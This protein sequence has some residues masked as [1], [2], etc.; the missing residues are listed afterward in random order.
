[1]PPPTLALLR[2]K[3]NPKGLTPLELG[4]TTGLKVETQAITA[5]GYPFGDRLAVQDG[6]YPSVSVNVGRITALRK[7]KMELEAIQVDAQV[8]P[9]NSGGPVTDSKGRVIG[10]IT[11]GVRGAG[12]NFAVPVSKVN[13][14]LRKPEV[15]FAPSPIPVAKQHEATRFTVRLVSFVNPAPKVAVEL[16][17]T[18]GGAERKFTATQGTNG[19][20]TV[21]AVPVPAAAGPRRVP[22]TLIFPSGRVQGSVE[23][24]SFKVGT[25]SLRLS[26]VREVNPGDRGTA[27]T[28]AG[29]T[30]SGATSGLGAVPVEFGGYALSVDL[31]KTTRI[32][33]EYVEVVP[34]QIE[35]VLTVTEGGKALNQLKGAIRIDG[36]P[37]RQPTTGPVRIDAPNLT[38][39]KTVVTLP[40]TFED[41]WVGGNGRYLIF[42]LRRLNKLAVFDVSAAKVIQYLPAPVDT[43]L[44]AAGADKLVLIAREKKTIERWTLVTFEKEVTA[45]LPVDFPVDRVASGAGRSGRYWCG[46][47]SATPPS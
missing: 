39:E 42:H 12:V 1:M 43:V 38:T 27:V 24:R 34:D 10:V 3:L 6:K 11:A 13:E 20:F 18:V 2:V 44:G 31:A 32:V 19:E 8:N 15:V 45:P 25:E 7:S 37:R 30:V 40:A 35:Y 22:V 5:F 16:A 29:R 9:G 23:D 36:A 14:F 41:V 4:T 47:S 28:R 33:A 21:E 46:E 17:L 26:D